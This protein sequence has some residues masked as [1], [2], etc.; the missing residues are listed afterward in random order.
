MRRQSDQS[1][2]VTSGLAADARRYAAGAHAICFVELLSSP[3]ACAGHSGAGR[4]AKNQ[5]QTE[6]DQRQREQ[7]NDHAR[8]INP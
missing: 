4:V 6:N 5:E 8:G 2:R 3:S 7:S 1:T